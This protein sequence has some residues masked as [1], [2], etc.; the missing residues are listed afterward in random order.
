MQ[1]TDGAAYFARAV[2]YPCNMFTKSTTGVVCGTLVEMG[3]AKE[4]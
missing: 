1:W 2:G 3:K 4:H